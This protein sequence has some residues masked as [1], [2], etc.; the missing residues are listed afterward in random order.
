ML[1]LIFIF[2]ELLSRDLNNKSRS[3]LRSVRLPQTRVSGF[4]TTKGTLIRRR[5][6]IYIASMFSRPRNKTMATVSFTT[7]ESTSASLHHESIQ[8]AR[9]HADRKR[10]KEREKG[11]KERQRERERFFLF[12]GRAPLCSFGVRD[13]FTIVFLNESSRK[14]SRA[15]RRR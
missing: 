15:S 8:C 9:A 4:I 12:S 7:N 1:S 2:Y 5:K 13:A 11:A 14:Y 6:S 10:E 3:I